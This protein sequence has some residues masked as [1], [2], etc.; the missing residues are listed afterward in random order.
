MYAA[1]LRRDKPFREAF[2]LALGDTVQHGKERLAELRKHQLERYLQTLEAA[3]VYNRAE[4]LIPA[5]KDV[6]E[7]P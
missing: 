5:F 7:N 6:I 3:S 1:D 2:I 4:T